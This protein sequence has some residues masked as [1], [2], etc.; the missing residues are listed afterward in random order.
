LELLLI[1]GKFGLDALRDMALDHIRRQLTPVNAVEFL[2]RA[3]TLKAELV[4]GRPL[5]LAVSVAC[6]SEREG[7]SDLV[8]C[9]C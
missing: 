3:V 1:A 6:G 7:D 2:R 9:G 4:R 8:G 5:V